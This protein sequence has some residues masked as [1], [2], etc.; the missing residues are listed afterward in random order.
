MYVCMYVC[1]YEYMNQHIR[2]QS[3]KNSY[4]KSSNTTNTRQLFVRKTRTGLWRSTHIREKFKR[5]TQLW[6]DLKSCVRGKFVPL[7]TMKACRESR[8]L[9]PIILNPGTRLK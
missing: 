2:L 6:N 8:Y 7:Y 9:A 5:D 3:Y 1:M 4:I